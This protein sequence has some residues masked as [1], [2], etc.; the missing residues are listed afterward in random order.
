MERAEALERL[1]GL[2]EA[3]SG[4][5]LAVAGQ[6]AGEFA[7]QR[8][9]VNFS[10]EV[11]Q[12]WWRDVLLVQAGAPELASNR[13]RLEALTRLAQAGSPARTRAYLARI[14]AA[15]AQLEQNVS[16]R[17]AFESLL[18]AIPGAGAN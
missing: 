17:L 1:L 10:L 7:R 14:E 9:S 8:Q 3:G 18:L 6:L 13:D 15:R 4:R 2:V 5:R 11:W 16:P 12:A